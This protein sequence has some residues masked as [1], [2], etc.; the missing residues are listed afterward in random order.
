M[1]RMFVFGEPE[2]LRRVFEEVSRM[3]PE[4][5]QYMLDHVL[6][7]FSSRHGDILSTFAENYDQIRRQIGWNTDLTKPRRLLLGSYFTMEYSLEAAALF[8]PSMTPHPDQEGVRNGDVRF[9]M[10]LRATGEGHVS[11]VVFRCGSI[12]ANGAVTIEPPRRFPV[13]MRPTPDQVYIKPLFLRTLK[14]MTGDSDAAARALDSYGEQFTYAQLQN[15]IVESRVSGSWFP[16][17]LETIESMLWIARSNYQVQMR[18]DADISEMVIFP[19]SEG[20]SR[21]IEDLRLVR[22][23][24]DDGEPTYYGTYTAYNGIRTLPMMLETKDFRKVDIHT[25]NGAYARNKGHALFPRRIKGH[26]VMCSRVDGQNLYIMSS[27]HLYFWESATLLAVPR[28]P[29]ELMLLGNCG[30]PIE[31]D[32][33]WLLITHGVGPMRQYSISAILLDLDDPTKTIGRLRDPLIT[34]TEGER[35]GYVPN[36]VYSCGSM[37]HQGVLYLPYAMADKTTTMATIELDALV[38]ALRASPP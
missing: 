30:S 34:P 11:S 2:R 19:Q 37:A 27:D 21:G 6:A 1:T 29:W 32:E 18:P 22:F 10:S 36:V 20:E 7:S 17:T 3:T 31:T 38:S 15:A 13:P 5:A 25:L 8:N 28:Y 35:E 16:L 12:G 9:L 24:E 23:V 26:Y 33:G 14:A 4:C